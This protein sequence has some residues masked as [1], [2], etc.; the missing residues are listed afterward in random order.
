M[1]MKQAIK[2]S[3]RIRIEKEIAELTE[4][5]DTIRHELKESSENCTNIVMNLFDG[6][7]DQRDLRMRLNTHNHVAKRVVALKG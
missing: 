4:A 2:E 7:Q 5:M 6:Y 1:K 3:V